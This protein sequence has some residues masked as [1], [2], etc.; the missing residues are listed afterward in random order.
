MTI[1]QAGDPVLRRPANRVPDDAIGSAETAQLIAAMCEVLGEVPGVGLAAPQIGVPLRVVVVQDLAEFHAAIPTELVT[2]LER[3]V[4]AR[5]VLI[6][7][8]IEP[9]GHDR[10][11]FFEGCLSVDGYRALVDRDRAVRV[12]WTDPAG[13]RH[14]ATR[15]GWHARILQHEVDHL[16]GVLYVDR[17][18][19][20]SFMTVDHCAN[21]VERPTEEALA[22][23]GID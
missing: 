5:Y 23:F 14:E 21:W 20:R 13:K 12:R 17:M 4:I 22:A 6:N 19:S 16:N 10:R 1:V 18:L 7:P 2:E 8:E 9:A 3:T 15:T 11:T